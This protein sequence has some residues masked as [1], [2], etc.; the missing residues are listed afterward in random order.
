M[1]KASRDYSAQ[2]IKIL[3]GQASHCAYPSCTQPLILPAKGVAEEMVLAQI[4]HIIAASDDGP[5]G[6]PSMAP[7]AR[8]E[9][10]N[11]LLMCPT[12]HRVVDVQFDAYPAPLLREWK[13]FQQRETIN[14]A[15]YRAAIARH[16]DGEL[17]LGAL[18]RRR[19]GAPPA[20]P[21]LE[22]V[23]RDATVAHNLSE[24][25]ALLDQ[26]IVAIIGGS[27]SGK[28]TLLHQL[29][30]ATS[31]VAEQPVAGSR[32]GALPLLVNCSRFAGSLPAL[33]AS[34]A[35]NNTGI[36][37]DLDGMQSVDF[38][39]NLYCDDFQYCPDKKAFLEQLRALTYQ[40][41]GVRCVL[42]THEL[43]DYAVLERFGVASYRIA[44]LDNDGLL[45]L[46]MG[47]MDEEAAEALL[48]DLTVR[49]EV[50]AFRQPVLA[51]LVAV[52]RADAPIEGA[53]S[54]TSLRR[55]ELLRRVI[56]DGVLAEWVA[57]RSPNLT[58]PHAEALADRLAD[59]AAWLV[60]ADKEFLP[61]VEFA[62]LSA[63]D[64]SG[65]IGLGVSCGLLRRHEQEIGFAHAAIR[66]YFAA[67]WLLTAPPR[68]VAGAWFSTSWHGALKNFA[69]L[70]PIDAKRLFWLRLSGWTSLQLI[71]ILRVFPNSFA[72]RLFYLM[73]EFAA[74]SR[75]DEAWLQLGIFN[76]YRRGHTF[77]D[78]K[79]A[80]PHP[81]VIGG[82]EDQIAHVYRLFGRLRRPEID[83]WL[84]TEG[85]RRYTIHGI[86]QEMT[87]AGLETLLRSVGS[88][89][90][91]IAN[92]ITVELAFEYPKAMLRRVF[93]RLVADPEIRHARLLRMI[94]KACRIR[95]SYPRDAGSRH[96]GRRD[97]IGTVL[98]TDPYWRDLLLTL[99]LYSEDDNLADAAGDLLRCLK[100]RGWLRDD[101]EA[102][103]LYAL[104]AGEEL[105]RR[106]ATWMLIYG[107]GDDSRAALIR[108]VREDDDL[109]V[110]VNACSSLLYRDTENAPA[111][112]LAVLQRWGRL[113]GARWEAEKAEI[114]R[115]V[116]AWVEE[117][118]HKPYKKYV[119]TFLA[120]LR[121]GQDTF[122]RMVAADGIDRILGR[123][124]ANELRAALETEPDDALRSHIAEHWA[125]RREITTDEVMSY[126]LASPEAALRSL[127]AAMV[128]R[129]LDDPSSEV[130][131]MIRQSAANEVDAQVRYD[132]VGALDYL[133]IR[134][135][136]RRRP[137][138]G[139][140][141]D[142]S[143]IEDTEAP[144]AQGNT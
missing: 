107:R 64:S 144:A 37:I 71:S 52:A 110:S 1:A 23:K 30:I 116:T 5:R 86:R 25:M 134:H 32:D 76:Q 142:E 17:S 92:D 63:G 143:E 58:S 78:E 66:D 108:A 115:T 45:D 19:D 118:G 55:G 36:A 89:N 122:E 21:Q 87:E 81:L 73:L 69:S 41:P 39:L 53:T 132:L 105:A 70:W 138:S 15:P 95:R 119:R 31:E 94:A 91:G 51:A 98:S 62:T 113:D 79:S 88:T 139:A 141:D 65:L 112:Y 29:A 49:G 100:S 125:T 22:S 27:G 56:R 90:D 84:R 60:R 47:F 130:Q 16:L 8:N 74:E 14:L 24:V 104:Q 128:R 6:D 136:M 72:T 33:I 123:V 133:K 101:V 20:E 48:D 9:P 43:P 114:A 67:E 124:I 38:P 46:F 11:L 2:T 83:Q 35:R 42:L 3:F 82:W 75:L 102:I 13:A 54:A 106:R 96:E 68:R 135:Q 93:D 40:H 18:F 126:L 10:D 129:R 57:S 137:Q 131:D 26:P 61:E 50:E 7:G 44:N 28:T 12:H 103:L 99:L 80:T 117:K 4:C 121:C 127:A 34:E 120:Y 111:H 140:E 97:R 85:N 59:I 109:L 77:L